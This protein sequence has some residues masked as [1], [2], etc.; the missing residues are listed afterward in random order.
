MSISLSNQWSELQQKA[1]QIWQS[2]LA[3]RYHALEEREQKI[4]KIAAIVLPLILFTF[5][6]LLPAADRNK[7][8][9]ADLVELSGKA[10]QAN[11]LADLLASKPTS[12]Q[13][14]S[15]GAPLTRIDQ[16]ARQTGVHSF[17]T[18]LRP[19]Q[20]LSRKAAI[21]LQMKNAP[22]QKVTTFIT[23][24]EKNGLSISQ[25]RLQAAGIGQV[26]LQAVI[27]S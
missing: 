2:K 22:Y 11:M 21:Q 10:Q 23:T 3:P 18:K 6:I 26:H 16:I 8:L 4:L 5:G 7:Q 27:D 12:L 17:V 1:E 24:L 19:Q 20:G 9:Q 13:P 14:N 15:Q 25:L